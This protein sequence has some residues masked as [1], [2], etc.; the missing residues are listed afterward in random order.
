MADSFFNKVCKVVK[1]SLSTF[2][3]KGTIL[4]WNKKD[5]TDMIWLV[6]NTLAIAVSYTKKYDNKIFDSIAKLYNSVL[7]LPTLGNTRN[8]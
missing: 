5:M 3:M 6:K 8:D 7:Y 1:K 4:K 2:L